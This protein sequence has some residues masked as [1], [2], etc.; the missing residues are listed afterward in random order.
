V[1]AG[2]APCE[3]KDQADNQKAEMQGREEQ[4]E[5]EAKAQTEGCG[6]GSGEVSSIDEAGECGAVEQG[7]AA[8]RLGYGSCKQDCYGGRE[9]KEERREQQV[10]LL[11]ARYGYFFNAARASLRSSAPS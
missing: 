9:A 1:S 11:A 2:R 4:G 3:I 7:V 6:E 8:M 10:I 5:G